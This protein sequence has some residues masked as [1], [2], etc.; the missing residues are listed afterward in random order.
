[1]TLLT[2]KWQ[3]WIGQAG[4]SNLAPQLDSEQLNSMNIMHVRLAGLQCEA[5]SVGFRIM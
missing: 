2:V 4:S 5:F 1:M 3:L